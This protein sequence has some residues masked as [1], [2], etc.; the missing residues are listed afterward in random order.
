MCGIFG[1][2]SLSKKI[3]ID[4][5]NFQL[6]L[7]HMVHRGPD[8]SGSFMNEKFAFGHRRLSIIDLS[9]K[10]KQ[11]MFSYDKSS[12]I[13]YNGEIYNYQELKKFLI[14]KGFKFQNNT[15]T[16]VLLN[17]LI[18]EG[19]KFID[20]CNGMFSFAYYNKKKNEFFLFRDRLGIKPLYYQIHNKNLIFSSN[21]K[22]ITLYTNNTSDINYESISSYF[23]YR[24]PLKNNTFYKNIKSLEP[25]HFIKIK[26]S[27]LKINKYWDQKKFF[28]NKKI[29]KS[30]D[31]FL[32]K[33][34]NILDSAV[35]YRLIS[36]VKVASLLSG[37]LDSSLIASIIN[38]KIH[39][40]FLAY[41]IGYSYKDYNEFKYSKL[42]AKK[43]N[44]KHFTTSTNAEQYFDD[45][46]ELINLRGMPL[47]IPNE[48]SQYRLCKEIKKKATVVL[49][50]SGADELFCGYG[51]IFGSVEDY[52]K[53]K[54]LEIFKNKIE[55]NKFLKNVKSRYGTLKFNNYLDHFLNIYSYTKDDLKSKIL[56]NNF[57]HVKIKK[58]IRSFFE[59]LF[60]ENK[61]DSYLDKMQYFFQ[62]FHLK[63]ILE[64][65]DISSMA[66]SIELRVPFLD[67]RMV[68]FA[69]TIPNEFKIKQ[70]NNNLSLTS[71]ISSE[72]LDT[73]KYILRKSYKKNIPNQIHDRKKIGFPVPLH[74]WM[75][76]KK[77]KDRVS[78]VLL[79]NDSKNRGIFNFNFIKKMLKDTSKEF[80]GSSKI[81][82]SS[83]ANKIWMC[84]NLERFF[85]QKK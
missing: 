54:N 12:I 31:Y 22:S 7:N 19:P 29:S 66:G 18:F 30:E 84:Y 5:N 21:V 10:G 50:G 37:G 25:G 74:I 49:S 81:Y 4:K 39:K 1:I 68:E 69:A 76:Q 34:Q 80:E 72:V 65:E 48:A 33:I 52:K 41:S 51:R 3:N 82:Q 83:A 45:V 28:L 16:E 13:T 61:S 70:L 2:I 35:S 59:N 42:V 44:M 73:T 71:D 78:D 79:S 63:G 47:T 27:Q 20:R 32:E 9:K 8:D 38:K 14:I 60:K 11:P 58:N 26:N 77:I 62:K 6:S 23:S 64:R 17:G 56:S 55:M 75:N 57:D 36:D 53:I 15:D 24:Q 43:L 46:D 67:H 85:S 40:N